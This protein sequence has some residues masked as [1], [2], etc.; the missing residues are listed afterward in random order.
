M[1]ENATFRA[2]TSFIQIAETHQITAERGQF[3]THCPHPE[4]LYVSILATV[5]TVIAPR[6]QDSA[7]TLHPIHSV[8]RI[9]GISKKSYC[10]DIKLPK[11]KYC[12]DNGI[13][14]LPWFDGSHSVIAE[15]G[16]S[17]MH[18]PQSTHLPASITAISST[19]IAS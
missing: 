6:G 15:D 9:R 14:P 13:C 7:H 11:G 10:K 12:F 5:S 2:F 1:C 4:H 8:S 16:H 3:L 18:A 17:S 19:V